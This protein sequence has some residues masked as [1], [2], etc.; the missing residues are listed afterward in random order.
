MRF[1]HQTRQAAAGVRT[2]GQRREEKPSE[3]MRKKIIRRLHE[4]LRE[5]QDD[6]AVGTGSERKARWTQA[7][8]GGQSV[9][10]TATGNTANAIAAATSNA[11]KVRIL[12]IL[13]IIGLNSSKTGCREKIQDL[14]R[15]QNPSSRFCLRRTRHCSPSA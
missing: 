3:T 2:K 13:Q 1:Q 5:E 9:D 14:S 15:I 10:G 11:T 12:I 4:I 6:V 8:K 7:A